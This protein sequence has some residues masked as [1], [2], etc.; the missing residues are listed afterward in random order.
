MIYLDKKI[1]GI[2]IGGTFIKIGI[3]N[4]SGDILHKWS[5]ETNKDNKGINIVKDIWESINYKLSELNLGNEI[6]GIGV[7]APGFINRKTGVVYEAV[8]IG[9]VNY[10]LEK[11]LK[12][13][14]NC[15]VF[16]ENDANLAALGENWRGGGNQAKDLIVL[17][18]GTG[19]G[20]GII[21]NGEIVSGT[22]GTAGEIGHISIDPNGYL[23]NCGHIGCLDTI[24]SGT[25]IVNQAIKCINENSK[26]P[27]AA[28]Y[29]DR[30]FLDA[31]D[32]FYLAS[33]GDEL[34]ISII[35]K[36]AD[37]IGNVLAHTA[38]VTNPSKIIIGGGVAKAGDQLLN[39]IKYS[40]G[41][42]SLPRIYK[43][44]EIKT[45]KLGNDAGIIGAAYLVI[46]QTQDIT[47]LVNHI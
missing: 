41:K 5:I 3:L 2:D 28:Y 36:V 19:V 22:N 14:S 8:N 47:N 1:I 12:E 43:C 17:T 18:L 32:V 30:H 27:L 31:K 46:H 11:Q 24:A 10:E 16:V 6:I 34:C 44:C 20:S 13:Y 7:G 23:C 25:G 29:L 26:S 33:K 38:T 21:V 42:Y 39:A 15:P 40:F 9:W 35:Q 45:A 4:E 37:A